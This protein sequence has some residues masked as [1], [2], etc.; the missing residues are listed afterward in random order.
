MVPDLNYLMRIARQ[1]GQILMEGYLKQHEIRHKGRIDL[2]T[3][4]DSRS[5]EYLLGEIRRDFKDHTIVTEESGLIEGVQEHCWFIDPLDGTSNYAHGVPVFSVTIAYA[6]HGAITLGVTVDPTRNHCFS[7]ERG[8]GAFLNGQPLHVSAT[9]ELVDAMLATGFPADLHDPAKNNLENFSRFLMSAQ[10]I[11][12]LGSAALDIAYVAAGWLDGYWEIGIHPWDIAAGTL[13]I[14]EAAGLV[15]DVQGEADFFKP[16][17][18]LIA[19]NPHLHAK[20]LA[21]LQMA[22]TR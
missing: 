8:Q 21:M 10:S 2:V 19:A 9:R 7:A 17:Y 11:R 16:P 6:F 20:M 1:A 14:Q 13:L 22:D 5:E 18:S 3:E 15:T 4:M 12:R